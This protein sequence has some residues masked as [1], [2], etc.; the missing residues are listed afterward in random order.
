MQVYKQGSL[1]MKKVLVSF[2]ACLLCLWPALG[3]AAGIAVPGIGDKATSL[4]GAF[5]ALAND[6]SAAWWN[7]AGLAYLEKSEFTSQLM[8]VS[9]RPNYTPDITT[10]SS[11]AYDLGYRNGTEWNPEDRHFYFPNAAGFYKIPT[12]TNFNAGV[13]ILFPYGLG[14]SW[15]LFETLPGYNNTAAFPR[16]DHRVNFVV[17]DVH[18]TIAKEIVQDKLSVG[19]GISIQNGDLL[20]QR[21]HFVP[22]GRGLPRPYDNFLMDS[23]TEANGW[24]VGVNLGFLYKASPKLNLAASFRSP[25]NIEMSGQTQQNVILPYNGELVNADSSLAPFLLG[26][27]AANTPSLDMTLKLPAEIGFGLALFASDKF[28]LTADIAWTQWSRFDQWELEYKSSPAT[29]LLG[30]TPPQQVVFNWDDVTSLSMGVEY[31]ALENFKVRAGY[32]SDP[33]PIP[34]QTISPLFLDYGDKNRLNLGGSYTWE[35]YEVGYNFEYINFADREVTSFTDVNG[36]G[37]Y[38]NFPGKYSSTFYGSHF[39]FT[40]RF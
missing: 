36:D 35:K 17:V 26:G 4:G 37:A 12:A 20:Y 2:C 30:T 18:P 27:V 34:D 25:V 28:T 31:L 10:S 23:K 32:S 8:I 38:D 16:V 13:A 39:Y 3:I 11:P 19:L 5:R 24:G 22:S 9:P 33:T 40:Y 7:P 29:P 15:D 1:S 14:S 21:I 6:W